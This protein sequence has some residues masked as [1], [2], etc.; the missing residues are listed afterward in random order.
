MKLFAVCTVPKNNLNLRI[1]TEPVM[2][3]LKTYDL[4]SN[5][6]ILSHLLQLW[7]VQFFGPVCGVG[8]RKI[9]QVYDY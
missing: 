9:M 7:T 6:Y 2:G 8:E 1:K 5:M 3:V 4:I